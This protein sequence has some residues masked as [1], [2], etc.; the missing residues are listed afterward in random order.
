MKFIPYVRATKYGRFPE[1]QMLSIIVSPLQADQS[2]GAL[3]HIFFFFFFFGFG[4][5]TGE[6]HVQ[7]QY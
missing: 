7:C 1:F 3:P 4:Y 6:Y 5:I 2:R